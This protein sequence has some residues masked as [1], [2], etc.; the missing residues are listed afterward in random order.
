[1]ASGLDSVGPLEGADENQ[2][3]GDERDQ[4]KHENKWTDVYS[5]S[6]QRIDDQIKGEQNHSEFFHGAMFGSLSLK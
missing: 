1:M 2:D 6:E 4:V 3:T 5:E